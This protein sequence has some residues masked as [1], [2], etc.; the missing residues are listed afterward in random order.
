MIDMHVEN[1]IYLLFTMT[2]IRVMM[3]SAMTYVP[4][5][6]TRV[7]RSP[8]PATSQLGRTRSTLA[9]SEALVEVSAP[10]VPPSAARQSPYG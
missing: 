5:H 7:P 3:A 9:A 2:K 6:L 8:H 4:G 1:E 10:M